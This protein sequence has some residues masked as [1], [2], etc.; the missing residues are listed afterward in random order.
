MGGFEKA[1]CSDFGPGNNPYTQ[2]SLKSVRIFIVVK[3]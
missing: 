3:Y 2:K 1:E